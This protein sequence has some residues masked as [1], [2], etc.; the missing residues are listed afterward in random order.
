[1]RPYRHRVFGGDRECQAARPAVGGAEADDVVERQRCG[2][3]GQALGHA[4]VAVD[5]L[6]AAGQQLVD[7]RPA[8][9]FR[10]HAGQVERDVVL[11][12][13]G[14]DDAVAPP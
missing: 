7:E 13:V 4:E 5:E 2:S 10:Q 6:R 14:G 3:G 1:L 9:P 12:R 11:V 8:V